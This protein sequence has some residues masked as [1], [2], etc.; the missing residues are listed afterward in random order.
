MNWSTSWRK[1]VTL[2]GSSLTRH[3]ALPDHGV[4]LD[5]QSCSCL[6]VG[7]LVGLSSPTLGVGRPSVMFLFDCWLVGR[8]MSRT[9]RGCYRRDPLGFDR[10]IFKV[11]YIRG[12]VQIPVR[13]SISISDFRVFGINPFGYFCTSG[14]WEWQLK[15]EFHIIQNYTDITS[16]QRTIYIL[17]KGQNKDGVTRLP[18]MEDHRIFSE[19][20]FPIVR[21]LTLGRGGSHNTISAGFGLRKEVILLHRLRRIITGLIPVMVDLRFRPSSEIPPLAV[22]IPSSNRRSIRVDSSS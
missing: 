11:A 3:V 16:E 2:T 8:P 20:S 13:V 15:N 17:K 14:R 6:I 1:F 22:A 5:G 10:F 12:G 7:W 21:A 19:C 9:V 4:W 18:Y